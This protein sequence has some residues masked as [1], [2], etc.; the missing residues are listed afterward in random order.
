MNTLFNPLKYLLKI[1]SNEQKV[2][3]TQMKPKDVVDWKRE[4]TIMRWNPMSSK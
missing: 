2:D 4:S 3:N 1:N